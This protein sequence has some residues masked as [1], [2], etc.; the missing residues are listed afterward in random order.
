MLDQVIFYFF[1][2]IAVVSA[3]LTVTRRNVVHSAIFLITA[4]L[5]TAGIFLQFRAQL[6]EDSGGCEQRSNEKDGT[7]HD[8]PPRDRQNRTDHGDCRKKVKDHLIKHKD[9]EW[10]RRPA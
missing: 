9:P 3:I 5:A 6:Q 2:A 8:I 4:L 7:M 10:H 1:A